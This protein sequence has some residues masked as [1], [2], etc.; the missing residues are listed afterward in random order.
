MAKCDFCDKKSI[1]AT[2]QEINH[3]CEDHE[4]KAL[5]IEKN[6]LKTLEVEEDK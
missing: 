5:E 1:G 6:F 3:Y 4:S 2:Y